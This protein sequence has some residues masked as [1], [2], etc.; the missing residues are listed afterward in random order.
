MKHFLHIM[1]VA[2]A[3]SG[4]S[5]AAYAMDI[6]S[7]KHSGLIGEKPNG[8][9]AATLPNPSPDLVQLIETTN[10]GRMDVY[11]QAA[12][13]QNIA[14]KEVQAIAAHKIYELANPG[15]FLMINGKWQK[16]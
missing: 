4:F 16:K 2:I 15:D 8:L 14:L 11:K 5:M 3:L 7:A 12:D 9:I 13:S 6:N 1:F 10:A